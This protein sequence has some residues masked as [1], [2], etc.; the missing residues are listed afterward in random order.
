MTTEV[1]TTATTR[2]GL[3]ALRRDAVLTQQELADR[4]GVQQRMVSKWENGE[5]MPRPSNIRKL[6]AIFG[7]EP[8]VVLVALRQPAAHEDA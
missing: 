3:R 4:I 1:R 5:T 7:V 8:G 6:A 2:N